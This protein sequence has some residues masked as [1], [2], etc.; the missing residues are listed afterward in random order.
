MSKASCCGV[1]SLVIWM[2]AAFATP[3]LACPVCFGAPDSPQVKGA[4][5]G[6]LALL[7]VTVV[8]LGAF[9]A[10]FLYLRRRLR[11]ADIMEPAS[12]ARQAAHG[13]S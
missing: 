4:Q 6:I 9:A 8:M 11:V 2:S 12:T 10:F 1:A 3:A 7:G 5:M 13:G